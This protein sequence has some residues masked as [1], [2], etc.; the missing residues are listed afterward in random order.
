MNRSSIRFRLT[1]L[2]TLAL[3]LVL[4]AF[5]SVVSILGR[6]SAERTADT[7]L[8]DTVAEIQGE[9]LRPEH[10]SIA[11]IL[12]EGH[13]AWVAEGMQ[14]S[15]GETSQPLRPRAGWRAM[16]RTAGSQLI[17]AELPWQPVER[18]LH[19]Q[20]LLL[21]GSSLL[22]CSVGFLG[23]WLLV[24]RA[25]A[26][27]NR[28]AQQA[29]DASSQS[30]TLRLSSP[31]NDTELVF[32]VTTLNGFLERTQQETRARRLFH[33]A[34]A[35]ELRTP[36]HVLAGRLELALSRPRTPPEYRAVLEE[37]QK[38]VGRLQ[39]LTLSLLTLTQQD[40]HSE[41]PRE[42]VDIAALC[43][44]LLTDTSYQDSLPATWT[45]SAPRLELELL[46]RNLLENATRHGLGS[47][48]LS[49]EGE[50]LVI[51]NP[52]PRSPEPQVLHEGLGLPLCRQVLMQNGWQGHWE[53]KE[54]VFRVVLRFS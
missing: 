50:T 41:R 14:V 44:T 46:L 1:T 36:L 33:A 38:Q 49:Q 15:V 37:L 40:T 4:L 24:G 3:A 31:S 11:A 13:D 9:L 52:C 30:P 35:H 6:R 23:A 27:I 47:L 51:E 18:Q 39:T 17:L 45:I 26:P 34:A 7:L 22:I 16:T 42:S 2:F 28:L 29:Q 10:D 43:R 54:D 25:L 12:D 8:N 32:L 19:Q 5:G 20:E 21:W 48:T 53:Q